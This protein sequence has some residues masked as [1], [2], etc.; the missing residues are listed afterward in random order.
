MLQIS[1]IIV[2]VF[3]RCK[4]Y[5]LFTI[6]LGLLFMLFPINITFN[7]FFFTNKNIQANYTNG[8][9]DISS[10]L[11]YVLHTFISSI[12]SSVILILL[13]FLCLTHGSIMS[14]RKIKDLEKA[15]KKA[16]WTIRC[17]KLRIL[18]YY[19][20]S[21]IF[22]LV[23]G[24]YVA[25]FCTIFENTQVELIKAMFTSWA[26]SLIYPLIICF[27]TTIF[28]ILALRCKK[29]F[30]YRVNQLLQMI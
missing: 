19:L 2:N 23:F 28:R 9:N 3:C 16:E 4:D 14:L 25:C 6:K 29:K 5:N 11:E 12:C 22:L 24:Y 26:M 17:I 20:L 27:V 1:H 8:I 21:F 30:L 15:K 10:I 13:K 18:T 7:S